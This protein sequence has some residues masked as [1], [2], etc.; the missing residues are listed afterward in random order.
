GHIR[1][2]IEAGR[3][4]AAAV[5]GDAA[6]LGGALHELA[7]IID[8]GAKLAGRWDAALVAARWGVG[9]QRVFLA[10]AGLGVAD[11]A[12]D[13]DAGAGRL[14][15]QALLAAIAGLAALLAGRDAASGGYAVGV[16]VQT[17]AAEDA[18]AGVGAAFAADARLADRA[19]DIG[20]VARV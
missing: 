15:A 13:A 10:V 11:K 8:A 17:G 9:A 2:D 3:V 6:R 20:R 7:G 19:A 14:D 12:G 1:L 4:L 18:V 16:A 5:P